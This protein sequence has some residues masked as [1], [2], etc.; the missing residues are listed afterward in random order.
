MSDTINDPQPGT[1]GCSGEVIR[2]FDPLVCSGE[3]SA[4]SSDDES[5]ESRQQQQQQ[6]FREMLENFTYDQS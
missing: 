1:S 3:L 6:Y 4:S 5:P 2:Q